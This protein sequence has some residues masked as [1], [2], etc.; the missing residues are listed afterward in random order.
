MQR[1]E[2]V[3]S[4]NLVIAVC[5]SESDESEEVPCVLVTDMQTKK[6]LQKITYADKEYPSA[7]AWHT[8]DGVG[9]SS[10]KLKVYVGTSRMADTAAGETESYSPQKGTLYCYDFDVELRCEVELPLNGA[11]YDI[12]DF[13]LGG[14][15]YIV[16]GINALVRIYS[17]E[18]DS[19]SVEKIAEVES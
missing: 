9:E 5:F 15:S 17:V 18:R 11:V 7:V 12:T 16:V 8:F 14:K 2:V 4:Y 13:M 19:D 3:E 6:I 10:P 1:F